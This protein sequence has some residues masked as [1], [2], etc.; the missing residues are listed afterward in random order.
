MTK[1]LLYFMSVLFVSLLFS[2]NISAQTYHESDK[3][4]LRNFLKQLS[5]DSININA[6][7]V[8][9]SDTT[10]WTTN[11]EWV[12]SISGIFWWGGRIMSIEW[13]DRGL[14]GDLDLSICSN[15]SGLSINDNEIT[16][17]E[18][19]YDMIS[20]IR[21][22][23]NHLKSI[24]GIGSNI[25]SIYCENNQLES[26]DF[27][28]VNQ[29][30]DLRCAKNKISMLDLS[31]CPILNYLDCGYNNIHSLHVPNCSELN[32]LYCAYNQ[33]QDMNVSTCN[34][35]ST[36][37][38]FDNNITNLLLNDCKKL[39]KIDCSSNPL[40][41][42]DFS[43][44]T[45]LEEL[46][47][48][49]TNIEMLEIINLKSLN[50]VRLWNN[51]KLYYLNIS[52]CSALQY[53]FCDGNQLRNLDISGCPSSM[54]VN[55]DRN[56]LPLSKIYSIIQKAPMC[57]AGFQ[58]NVFFDSYEMELGETYD[59][60]EELL[61]G[62]KTSSV[63]VYRDDSQYVTKGSGYTLNSN[64]EIAF[65]EKGIY[66][67]YIQNEACGGVTTRLGRIGVGISLSDFHEGDID[68]LRWIKDNTD[69]SGALDW[70]GDDYYQ[71]NNIKWDFDIVPYR[72]T[73]IDLQNKN[74]TGTL[75][76]SPLEELKTFFC[77]NS[78]IN[79]LNIEKCKKLVYMEFS[80]N[81]LS[82]LDVSNHPELTHV[83]CSNN[84][85]ENI[86]ISACPKLEYVT[87]ENNR[88]PLSKL[89]EIGK[90]RNLYFGQQDS[91]FFT[92]KGI[93][94]GKSIQLKSET[95]IAENPTIFNVLKN[96]QP[97]TIGSD[98]NMSDGSIS[99]L[100]TGE[101][102]IEMSNDA[103]VNKAS[104]PAKIS[105]GIVYVS[106]NVQANISGKVLIGNKYGIEMPI[107]NAIV[108]LYQKN[109][110]DTYLE[111]QNTQ[112]LEDGSYT[113]KV[114]VGDYVIKAITNDIENAVPS[115]YSNTNTFLNYNWEN[116]TMIHIYENNDLSD[117]NVNMI[118]SGNYEEGSSEINGYISKDTGFLKFASTELSEGICVILLIKD[119]NSDGFQTVATTKTDSEG[120]YTFKNLSAGKYKVLVDM[121]GL[122]ISKPQ[123]V[124]IT[125][126]GQKL[127]NVNYEISAT[128]IE[129]K[130]YV[131]INHIDTD[132][133][134]IILYPNPVSDRFYINSQKEIIQV[135][136]YNLQGTLQKSVLPDSNN[137]IDVNSFTSGMY[138]VHVYLENAVVIGKVLKK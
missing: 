129:A 118:I 90:G 61:L 117:I 75:N 55:C 44:C 41:Y 4:A 33:L 91:V 37:L 116:A 53:L 109:E 135:E 103:V 49:G 60:N 36:L 83:V 98:Y 50:D 13:N 72:V 35:L 19:P 136:I 81:K 137:S 84:V 86:N 95:V 105:T 11:E 122:T 127:E 89:Y 87:C 108:T 93:E 26:L 71:W 2:N 79:V 25:T 101:Y 38:C 47:C 34:N 6:V 67:V 85:I 66:D 114:K 29:L 42:V 104:N 23:N 22:N 8:G 76:L 80:K 58:T 130:G 99:F 138:V 96:E 43:T 82:Y 70:T 64:G 68:A 100:Q 132:K 40:E 119:S 125:Q 78:S 12:N 3:E 10:N 120:F 77:T 20:S 31:N 27:Y 57:N 115:Y 54:Q 123:T 48:C 17:L 16:R 15:L 88:I 39:T 113:F 121:P 1:K 134:D 126:D 14:A 102:K 106:E 65:T 128:A 124:T 92:K 62:G 107:D 97:A 56:K 30:T 21:C 73:R 24:T 69:H 7:K 52:G 110:D 32:Y 9:L 46:A 111:S 28:A 133:T 18:L 5:A 51:N 63:S 74:L 112:S 94:V 59:L 131:G 45:A